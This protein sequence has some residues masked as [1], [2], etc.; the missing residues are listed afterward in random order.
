MQQQEHPTLILTPLWLT[1]SKENPE[2]S[3]T[4][5]LEAAVPDGASQAGS[6]AFEPG[7]GVPGPFWLLSPALTH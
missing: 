5:G 1:P 4:S 2:S 6:T 7:A 3:A